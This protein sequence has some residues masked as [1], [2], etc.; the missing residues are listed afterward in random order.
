MPR[1]Q[2]QHRIVNSYG[3][4]VQQSITVNPRDVSALN[5]TKTILGVVLSV[6]SAD[7]DS[8]RSAIQRADR[9]G[10]LHTCTVLVVEDGRSSVYTLGNVVITPDFRCGVDDYYERLPRGC[11]GLVTGESWNSELNNINP[12]D[13]DGD[14]C[15]VGF[16][17]GSLDT[18]YILRWWPHPRNPYDVSTSGQRNPADPSSSP[19]LTQDGRVLHRTN[20]VEF[21]VTSIGDV[22]MSTNLASSDLKFGDPLSPENGR[23]PRDTDAD[24]G[25]SVKAWIKPSQTLELDWNPPVNGIG[26]LD[27]PDPEI[28]QTNPAN[29]GRAEDKQNSYILLDKERALIEVPEKLEVI[30][31]Q[32]ILLTSE[33]ETILTVGTDLTADVSQSC[34]LTVGS[35]L[36]AD[37]SGSCTLKTPRFEVVLNESAGELKISNRSTGDNLSFNAATSTVTLSALTALTLSAV[38]TVSITG[39]NIT[40]NGRVV[41]P[42]P[43]PI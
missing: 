37:V 30:S 42:I 33:E 41:R 28:P 11:S 18:P 31:K 24:N 32:Q 19:Y 34:T 13:L 17:G 6:N 5:V 29:V 43:D 40:L 12:Y 16:L 26:I 1:V 8:N 22:Y 23:F 25:G 14:W 9:R 35:D 27:A 36:T 38:G 4:P 10:Y 39:A 2:D 20:G 3:E 21:V 15:I 7:N